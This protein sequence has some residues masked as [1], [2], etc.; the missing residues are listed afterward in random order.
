MWIRT[1][2]EDDIAA[3]GDVIGEAFAAQ[4]GGGRIERDIV[5]ALRADSALALS[6]VAD[7]DGRVAG[8]IAFSAVRIEDGSA[9]WYGLGP[10]AVAA[11]DQRHGVGKAL[12]RAGLVELENLGAAGC[13]VLGDPGYYAQFGFRAQDTLIFEGV[14]AQY[15]QALAL[16]DGPL[17][18]GRV[19][20]HDCFYPDT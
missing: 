10:V 5:D 15:F 12:V 11:R 19:R 16:T 8:H 20:Y 1:E 9:G 14:P 2:S 7:I 18:A 4:P 13:V 6:L 17:P 3:I